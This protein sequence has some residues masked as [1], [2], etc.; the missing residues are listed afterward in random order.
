MATV[1]MVSSFEVKPTRRGDHFGALTLNLGEKGAFAQ[2]EAKM[3]DLDARISRGDHPPSAG[4]VIEIEYQ[5]NEYQGR[6]QWIIKSFRVLDGAE[7]EGRLAQFSPPEQIDSE[8]YRARL[9]E[10]IE[11]T[12]AE[13]VSGLLV[14]QIF[15]RSG[16][17]EAFYRSP[18][19]FRHHQNY[20]GGLLEHT[21]NVTSLALA[22]AE[23]Y[24][25]DTGPGL[26][27]NSETLPI[28]RELLTAAGLLHD[29]GKVETYRLEPLPVTTDA[30]SWEGHLAISYAVVRHEAVPLMETPPYESA[31]EELSKLFHCILSHHGTL[32]Y[33][34][35]VTPAC[36]EA[37]LLSQADLADARLADMAQGGIEALARD[38]SKRWLPRSLHFPTGVFI[39]DWPKPSE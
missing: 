12:S 23:S 10:L 21:I 17:R 19:A 22:M 6:L 33:G 1:V 39:G 24:A 32:E 31:G 35:P 38:P 13:R 37:F 25:S 29:I 3:W 27:F 15:D 4:D 7:R 36:V 14:R 30:N 20:P 8:F 28:D 2:V 9:E 11:R 5:A 16:F 18:A 34:S 26:T